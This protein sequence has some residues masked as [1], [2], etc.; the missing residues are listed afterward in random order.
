MSKILLVSFFF[1]VFLSLSCFSSF[2]SR[3]LVCVLNKWAF[4]RF[5]MNGRSTTERKGERAFSVGHAGVD[6]NNKNNRLIF[7]MLILSLGGR[8]SLG[9]ALGMLILISISS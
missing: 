1:L 5:A 2:S 4:G 8:K 7:G 9:S 6:G 3:H